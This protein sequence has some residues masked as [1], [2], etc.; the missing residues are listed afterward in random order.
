MGAGPLDY[1]IIGAGPAGLQ[2]LRMDWN[3]LL[4]PDSDLLI[5]RYSERYFP[6]A[7]GPW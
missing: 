6:E 4:S 2:H 7:P 3:S 5:T 1:L